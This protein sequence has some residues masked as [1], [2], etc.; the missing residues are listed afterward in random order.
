MQIALTSR[1]TFPLSFAEIL[2]FS[3]CVLTSKHAHVPPQQVTPGARLCRER[4][5]CVRIC[6]P[7]TIKITSPNKMSGRKES[8]MIMRISLDC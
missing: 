5:D 3:M 8:N 7:M 1:S 4:S 6:E 2:P